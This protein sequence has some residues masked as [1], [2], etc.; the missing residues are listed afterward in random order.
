VTRSLR[1]LPKALL[2]LHLEAAM[3]PSTLDELAAEHG[4]D[5]P[6]LDGFSTFPDFIRLYEAATEVLR[7]PADVQRLVLELAEDAAADGAT[8][9]EV[10]H[11]P[12]LWHGR[13]GSD[14][15]TLDLTLE[16]CA[17]ATTATGVGIGVVLSADRTLDP[18][19]GE[20][21][22]RL[23]VSRRDAGVTTF[24]LANDETGNPPDPYAG[25]FRIAID[26]GLISAPHAGEL[27]GPDYVRT[28]VEVLAAQRLG[29]GVRAVEDPSLVRRLADEGI[30][31][32]V[33]PTSNLVLGLFPS[34][35]QHGIGT[36]LEAGVPVTINTDDPL[37]FGS[38]LLQEWELV[39]GA[40]GLDDA[41]MAAIARTS[42]TA[43]GASEERKRDA[44]A[45]IDAWLGNGSAASGV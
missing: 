3:R 11:Y 15:E 24:G 43:S 19:E 18:A 12:P 27:G 34:I 36:L 42:I 20:R 13:F 4:V 23:A 22:A 40:F 26:G 14:E 6:A 38:G 33:C 30:V 31:C 37:L 21:T 17:A 45:G 2:H 7:R 16:A 44:L 8:W 25:A 28:A 5:V 10:H 9:V 29:H 1:D 32:D 41:A 39:R 35:E